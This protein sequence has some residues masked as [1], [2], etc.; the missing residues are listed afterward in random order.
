MEE[1]KKKKQE[2]LK[3]STLSLWKEKPGTFLSFSF[4]NL[5]LF[6]CRKRD[7]RL[8]RVFE[9]K[10][11]EEQREEEKKKK[12]EQKMAQIEVK[13][14]VCLRS[15]SFST[16]SSDPGLT[17]LRSD[18]ACSAWRRRRPRKKQLPNVKRNWSRRRGWKKRLERRN[19]L[20]WSLHPV[21]FGAR[22]AVL[23]GLFS[24]EGGGEATAGVV[25]QEEGRGGGT[26]SQAG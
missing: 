1:E 20:G 8:K 21:C 24:P 6:C 3:R 12:V 9:A 13:N 16:F 18:S 4:V 23:T 19:W 11:K 5:I 17:G 26:C 7:E 14:E 22:T 2:E 10:V 15:Y 25:G